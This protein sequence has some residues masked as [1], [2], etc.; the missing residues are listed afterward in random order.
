MLSSLKVSFGYNAIAVLTHN[1][2]WVL[3]AI[4]LHLFEAFCIFLCACA[5]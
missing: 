5:F 2:I 1:I 4:W 3:D